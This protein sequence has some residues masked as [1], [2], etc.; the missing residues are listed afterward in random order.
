MLRAGGAEPRAVPGVGLRAPLAG[1]QR[2]VAGGGARGKRSSPSVAPHAG[3]GRRA[4]GLSGRCPRLSSSGAGLRRQR[5]R[6]ERKAED[7]AAA[8]LLAPG[9]VAELR[10]RPLLQSPPLPC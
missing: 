6:A 4:G 5:Q 8:A 2:P 1:V 9:K 10:P 3:C 7:A